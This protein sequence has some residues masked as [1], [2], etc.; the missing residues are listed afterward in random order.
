MKTVRSG[1]AWVGA[2]PCPSHVSDHVVDRGHRDIELSVDQ[3]GELENRVGSVGEGD[4]DPAAREGA[5]VLRDPDRPIESAREDDDRNRLE[6]LLSTN[7]AQTD[8]SNDRRR[9]D[10]KGR[11]YEA[12]TQFLLLSGYRELALCRSWVSRHV[13]TLAP[14]V[15]CPR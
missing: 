6:A 9:G 7:S 12:L 14:D 1:L 8:S 11:R 10:G 13:G 4:F 2:S 5:F 3:V 15:A